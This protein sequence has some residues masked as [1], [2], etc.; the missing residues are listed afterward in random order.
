MIK[1]IFNV[2]YDV[3]KMFSVPLHTMYIKDFDKKK[4]ELIDY[5][6]NLKS[7][8]SGRNATNRGGWQSSVFPVKGGDVL[9]DLILNLVSN[10][11]SFRTDR[12]I[13]TKCQAWV[14]INS[15]SSYNIK[16]CHPCSDLAGVLWIKIPK[17]SGQICFYSPYD[18]MCYEEIKSYSDDF[19]KDTNYYYNYSFIPNEGLLVLFPSHLQH[20]VEVNKSDEDRISVSFNLKLN[21]QF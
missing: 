3:V 19:K 17:N 10:I 16:H 7:K 14:N 18:Y 20:D 4:E 9:Q 5:V 6:Y 1:E 8:Q 13:E 11:P 15:P 2:E 12:R 21:D